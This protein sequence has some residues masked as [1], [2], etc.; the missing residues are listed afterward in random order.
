MN[1][2]ATALAIA[3]LAVLVAAPARSADRL[4]VAEAR[5][6]QIYTKGTSQS[7]R[8]ITA[9]IS[10][11]E[12]PASASILPCIQCHGVDGSGIGIVSPNINWKVLTDPTGHEHPQRSHGSF[13]ETSLARAISAGVDP[14][15]NSLEATMPRY[16]MAHEDMGDLIAYLKR[17][18][19]EL[20]PGLS[21]STIN[22]GTVL[23]TA[24]PLASIG[25]AMRTI[26]EAYFRD[27]NAAGGVHG[28]YLE[29]V[30]GEYGA[31][32]TPAYWRA[33]DLVSNESLFALI[34]SYLPGYET[35]FSTLARERQ[36]PLIGA[37]KLLNSDQGG[38]YEF[39]IQAGL[40]EQAAALIEIAIADGKRPRMAVVYPLVQ[41]FDTLADGV[42]QH[43]ENRGLDSM[44]AVPYSLNGFDAGNVAGKLSGGD[45]DAVVFLGSAAE[46]VEFGAAAGMLNWQPTLLAPGIFAERAVFELPKTFGGHVYLAYASLPVDHTKSGIDVFEGLHR[47]HEIDYR[48]SAAQ[49]AAFSAARVLIE[50]LERAGPNLSREQL[51]ASLESLDEYQPGLTAAVSFGPDQRVGSVGAHVVRVDLAAGRLD[52]EQEW[53]SLGQTKP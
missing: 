24:G 14:D 16:V 48:N 46:F 17:I 7:S 19:T 2:V 27:I 39:Q 51:I 31:D 47:D 15:G 52:A 11:S 26:I 43:A 20:D 45:V 53:I 4:S 6:K 12:A 13:D 41:G 9:A 34:A 50:A 42:R 49:I 21:A 40:A 37:H 36:I 28:R 5:G 25:V 1:R 23:P 38:R 33:Q 10:T 22:I 30:V 35:E 29:F 3:L 18:D 44:Y 32:D 8:I